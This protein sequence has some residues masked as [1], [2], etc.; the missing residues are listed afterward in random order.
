MKEDLSCRHTKEMGQKASNA[1]SYVANTHIY[2]SIDAVIS[3]IHATGFT[4]KHS[5]L[6]I[7]EQ[8]PSQYFP[9]FFLFLFFP[10]LG[11]HF[12]SKKENT[13]M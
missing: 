10:L 8:Q 13:I 6:K 5:L 7:S 9:M 1:T 11:N 12:T 2:T 4:V 3:I